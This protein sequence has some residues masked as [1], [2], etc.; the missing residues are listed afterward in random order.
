MLGTQTFRSQTPFPPVPPPLNRA[1]VQDLKRQMRPPPLLILPWGGACS[2]GSVFCHCC[3]LAVMC[4]VSDA[5]FLALRPGA[6]RVARFVAVSFGS[7]ARFVAVSFGSR[8][9]FF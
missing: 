9:L 5:F 7:I 3:V 8:P 1:S 4:S 2:V 6:A